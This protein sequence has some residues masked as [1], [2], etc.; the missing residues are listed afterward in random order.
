[1][2][3]KMGGGI[4]LQEK[5]REGQAWTA[6]RELSQLDVLAL[7]RRVEEPKSTGPSCKCQRK[8]VSV[9]WPSLQ[10]IASPSIIGPAAHCACES[11]F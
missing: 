7:Y 5:L 9:S 3:M 6:Q 11:S 8:V 10:A 2:C 1:M 4:K